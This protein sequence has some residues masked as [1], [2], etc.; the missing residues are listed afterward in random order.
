LSER[1][2]HARQVALA[3]G[4]H[5]LVFSHGEAILS[6]LTSSRG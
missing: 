3:G 2:P 1:L 4:G 5:F 6:S